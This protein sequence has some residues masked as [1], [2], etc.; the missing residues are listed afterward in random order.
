MPPSALPGSGPDAQPPAAAGPPEPLAAAEPTG[1]QQRFQDELSRHIQECFAV[2]KAH[3]DQYITP[4]LYECMRRRKGEYDP[5]TLARIQEAGGTQTYFNLTETKCDALE[6]W[7]QDV[8]LETN[9][10]PWTLA[11]SP[12]P[13]LPP[14]V[15]QGIQTAIV[16]Q[17]LGPYRAMQAEFEQRTT[18]MEQQAAL[19]PLEEADNLRAQMEQQL[20]DAQR[21]IAQQVQQAAVAMQEQVARAVEDEAKKRCE[22]METRIADLLAEGGW[23]SAMRGMIHQLA[24]FPLAVLKGPVLQGRRRQYWD[25]GGTAS[26]IDEPIPTFSCPSVFDIYPSPSALTIGDDWL[27][28]VQHFNLSDLETEATAAGWILPRVRQ[29]IAEA[30]R[31]NEPPAAPT[32]TQDSTRATLERRPL[33][34]T[35]YTTK[36]DALEWWGC[37]P[38]QMLLDWAAHNAA[39]LE[40]F[41]LRG[42]RA[43]RWYPITATYLGSWVVKVGTIL[44]PQGEIPYSGT[45]FSPIPGSLAGKSLPEKLADTQDSYNSANRALDNNG[46]FAAGPMMSY[47]ADAGTPPARVYPRMVV[48]YSGLKTQGRSPITF[49]HPDSHVEQFLAVATKREE[50]ADDRVGI[51]KYTYG[52]EKVGG[53]GETASGLAMLMGQGSKQIKRVIANI[54]DDIQCPALRRMIRFCNAYSA[55]KALKGDV[56]V[57]PSG[58]L[59]TLTK[60]TAGMRQSEFI[61]LAASP[62]FQKFFSDSGIAYTLRLLATRNDLPGDKVIKTDEQIQQEAQAQMLAMQQ[63]QALDAEVQA[64]KAQPKPPGKPAASPTKP[65]PPSGNPQGPPQPQPAHAPNQVRPVE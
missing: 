63:Q 22:E 29:V 5:S 41:G 30:I 45:S 36:C 4:I 32:D 39:T 59:K 8:F 1:E 65:K 62:V 7:V 26:V 3:R 47:D 15:L 40:Q 25:D 50:E 58:A 48:L 28:E 52:N 27:I 6:A 51:P 37:V 33:T 23:K 12:V 17:F 56:Q 64:A 49:F 53:A 35:G 19:L 18:L 60:D 43:D 11:P 24:T 16:D 38:G 57:Q 9:D 20:Q 54:D 13:T 46:A 42:I 34:P 2:A 55:D 31:A 44:D 21:E 14:Q 10:R 61:G